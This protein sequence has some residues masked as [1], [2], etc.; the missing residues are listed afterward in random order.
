MRSVIVSLGPDTTQG[1]ESERCSFCSR[2]GF[3][4]V[5]SRPGCG[6]TLCHSVEDS[7]ACLDPLVSNFHIQR[8]AP[9]FC[10]ARRCSQLEEKFNSASN[11][12]FAATHGCA[13]DW[14]WDDFPFQSGIER[15]VVPSTRPPPSRKHRL[16][17]NPKLLVISVEA[18][19]PYS[20]ITALRDAG[21]SLSDKQLASYHQ[22]SDESR[23][24]LSE[25]VASA[26]A[27]VV[28]HS[29]ITPS[30][31]QVDLPLLS[32][33]K[34]TF[35]TTQFLKVCRSARDA[36]KAALFELEVFK[37]YMSFLFVL[38]AHS[39][40]PIDQT[41]FSLPITNENTG[42][43]LLGE[44]ADPHALRVPLPRFLQIS[45]PTF[46]PTLPL[47]KSR[48]QPKPPKRSRTTD[49][50]NS[51]EELDPQDPFN[52]YRALDYTPQI[53]AQLEVIS[54]QHTSL[55]PNDSRSMLIL[56][57]CG[58]LAFRGYTFLRRDLSRPEIT[59]G[60]IN[61]YVVP[62]RLDIWVFDNVSLLVPMAAAYLA[63]G[64]DPIVS[65][66]TLFSI[67]HQRLSS[68]YLMSHNPNFTNSDATSVDVLWIEVGRQLTRKTPLSP[69]I[70]QF[71]SH[72]IWCPGDPDDPQQYAHRLQFNRERTGKREWSVQCMNSSCQQGRDIRK[73]PKKGVFI[74]SQSLSPHPLELNQPIVH[75]ELYYTV[76]KWN[77]LPAANP[78]LTADSVD[79]ELSNVFIAEISFCYTSTDKA[80]AEEK[81]TMLSEDLLKK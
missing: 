39:I 27:S 32:P 24:T 31:Q 13:L 72:L 11:S 58:W 80:A 45:L 23:S 37:D 79:G 50:D 60:R 4:L 16:E 51:H 68:I 64:T 6:N 9:F 63:N 67:H 53:F 81:K 47:P 49:D 14:F 42:M 57:A 17:A 69:T 18:P 29:S 33:K 75:Q 73:L 15:I 78:S 41:Q 59:A 74:L 46:F 7:V 35:P 55:L 34:P 1:V 44:A 22:T 26:L 54:Q 62:G 20:Q 10:S 71:L 36:E 70:R 25:L 66:R 76:A 38:V 48:A 8:H 77:L 28:S 43:L 21:H 12:A 3:I 65:L 19:S 56:V 40:E 61:Y 30:Y 2:A 5:C 52:I